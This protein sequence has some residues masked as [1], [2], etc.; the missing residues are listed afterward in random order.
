VEVPRFFGELERPLGPITVY[1][2]GDDCPAVSEAGLPVSNASAVGL[3]SGEPAMDLRKVKE[4]RSPMF[5]EM[6]HLLRLRGETSESLSEGFADYVQYTMQP[7]HGVGFRPDGLDVNSAAREAMAEYPEML[8]AIGSKCSVSFAGPRRAGN[9]KLREVLDS[10]GEH[11]AWSRTYAAD[12]RPGFY[13]A[14]HSF[15]K[16][17]VARHG[18]GRVVELLTAG[19][20]KRDYRRILG[21]SHGEVRRLWRHEIQQD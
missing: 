5:H 9:G 16:F 4:G 6:A 3:R 18:I 1:V 15:V 10:N 14:S 11:Q 8:H 21:D 2:F 17:L 12:A 13:Y 7:G 19:G 20:D